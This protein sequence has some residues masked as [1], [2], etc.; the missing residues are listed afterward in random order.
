MKETI[1]Y[2]ACD[3]NNW[4]DSG[5]ISK[6]ASSLVGITVYPM[7]SACGQLGQDYASYGDHFDGTIDA[8]ICPK[9]PK[10]EVTARTHATWYGAPAPLFSAPDSALEYHGLLVNGKVGRWES[11][12]SCK[13]FPSPATKDDFVL[14]SQKQIYLRNNCELYDN[15]KAGDFVWD[16][17]A[18][19]QAK[20]DGSLEG[21]AWWGRGVIQTTGRANFGKLNH[22]LA[23][24]HL[25]PSDSTVRNNYPAPENPIYSDLDLCYNPELI[26]SSTKH[27]ELKW[28]AGFF[29]W[30]SSVQ[31][32][33]DP[34]YPNFN[35]RQKL[36]EFV[37]GGMEDDTF[38]G[39]VSGIVNRGCPSSVSCSAGA[40]DGLSERIENFNTVLEAMGLK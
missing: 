32:Y 40:V 10:M 14:D 30:M 36:K 27:P 12:S 18:G 37:D 35:Y 34:A 38:I 31:E 21:C 26:C 25:D 5:V 39:S 22:Y 15:Q 17:S 6:F 23:R 8:F 19:S 33:D 24:S 16:G 4:S 13:K 20:N 28:I 2:D 7:T 1:Q 3:E 9:Y 11:S 29:Y